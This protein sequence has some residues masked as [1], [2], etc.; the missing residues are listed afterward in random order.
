MM[1]SVNGTHP[2]YRSQNHILHLPHLL[3]GM[4]SNKMEE[5]T[6]LVYSKSEAR[7]DLMIQEKVANY[8]RFFS[9][10]YFTWQTI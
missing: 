3:L 10:I 1:S 4:E 6:I 2:Q 5:T 9:K 8:G 7:A